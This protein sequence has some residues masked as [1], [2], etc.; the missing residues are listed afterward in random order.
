MKLALYIIILYFGLMLCIT[1]ILVVARRMTPQSPG[2]LFVS[3]RTGNEELFMMYDSQ[4]QQITNDARYDDEPAWSKDGRWLTFTSPRDGHKAI[5][6]MRPHGS[7][8]TRLTGDPPTFEEAS[9]WSPDGQWIVFE[10]YREGN[11]EIYKMRTNGSDMIQ[12]TH[13][14]ARD[15]EPVWSPT[16]EWIAFTSNR[17]RF[18]HLYLMRPD[19]SGLRQLTYTIGSDTAPNWSPDG[20][21]LVYQSERADG[22]VARVDITT[23]DI[24]ILSS[25]DSLLMDRQPAWSPDGRWIAFETFRDGDWE[26][27]RMKP[28]GSQVERLT[29]SLGYD[30]QP[31]WAPIVDRAWRWWMLPLLLGLSLAI[32]LATRQR[33]LGGR[34][35]W[36]N[37]HQTPLQSLPQPH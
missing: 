16:G 25:P 10:A 37:R 33:K 27:Y 34:L 19:G 7:Q 9:S 13:H 11:W 24:H 29:D 5:Y 6:R 28:D 14:N 31:T 21:S 2:I 8:L 4:L 23:G 18:Y 22:G 1:S 20:R 15:R 35:V 12:L 17:N 30:G 3:D 36:K 32:Y 26:I